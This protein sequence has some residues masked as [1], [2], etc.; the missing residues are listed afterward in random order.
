[1]LV[2]LYVLVMVRSSLCSIQPLVTEVNAL[3]VASRLSVLTYLATLT[4]SYLQYSHPEIKE[5]SS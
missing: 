3:S 4:L 2:P 1:M 5:T